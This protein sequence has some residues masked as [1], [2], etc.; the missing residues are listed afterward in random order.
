MNSDAMLGLMGAEVLDGAAPLAWSLDHAGPM[1]RT[2]QDAALLHGVLSGQPIR[3]QP[4]T[5]LRLGLARAPYWEQLDPE[6][7]RAML[8]TY[9]QRP[10]WPPVYSIWRA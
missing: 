7:E 1:T 4:V 10:Q 9:T 8:A 6:V 3:I 5:N 2:A